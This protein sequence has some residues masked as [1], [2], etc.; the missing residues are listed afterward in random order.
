[1][2]HLTNL[3][4]VYR[5]K[6]AICYLLHV[7]G[8]LVNTSKITCQILRNLGSPCADRVLI[9]LKEFVIY[10]VWA[11][12]KKTPKSDKILQKYINFQVW[13]LNNFSSYQNE[14]NTIPLNFQIAFQWYQI[15][16]VWSTAR[17][18][19]ID[20]LNFLPKPD[21]LWG[22]KMEGAHL[23]TPWISHCTCVLT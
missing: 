20:N 7:E 16:T 15:H 4:L 6:Y 13:N 23:C 5:K 9:G 10:G 2:D 17:R 12:K 21:F 19:V 8:F 1:M 22:C 11:N 3:I 14:T 18:I